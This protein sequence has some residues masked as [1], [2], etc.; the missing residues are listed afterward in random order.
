MSNLTIEQEFKL[1]K[2]AHE[3]SKLSEQEVKELLARKL[4][5][6]MHQ[7][8]QHKELLAKKWGLNEH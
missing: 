2:F 1:K 6:S 7:H 3:L 5:E 4:E 8:N